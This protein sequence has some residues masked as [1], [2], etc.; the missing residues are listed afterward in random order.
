MLPAPE[1]LLPQLPAGTALAVGFDLESVERVR[2]AIE[3]SGEAFL[4]RVFDPGEIEECRSR[5]NACWQSFAA[6]WA[7]KEAFAKAA[8]TGIG[9]EISFRDFIVES[10]GNG[11]PHAKLS[12]AGTRQM[13]R[14]GA[15]RVLLSLSHS[16][17]F[18]G[19][20]VVLAR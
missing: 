5:G 2:I 12:A 4:E 17:G 11:C 1:F 20:F 13:E 18:A 3:R 16:H 6:R 19:A 14:L 7:A 8:G 9:A 10:D 15:S